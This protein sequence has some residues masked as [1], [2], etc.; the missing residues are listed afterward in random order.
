MNAWFDLAAARWRLA[1]WTMVHVLW[2]VAVVAKLGGAVRLAFRRA[3]TGVRYGVSLVTLAAL[4]I[5]PVGVAAWLA[6]HPEC[7]ASTT[8]GSTP[9]T[10]ASAHTGTIPGQSPM[11]KDAAA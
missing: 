11:L 1:G 9:T 3:G 10:M 2:V 5:A 7:W 4:A 6:V 8:R